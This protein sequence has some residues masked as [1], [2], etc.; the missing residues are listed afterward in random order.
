MSRRL[1][2]MGD[3]ILVRVDP[4]SD[5]V[6]SGLLFK[7]DDAHET[8]IQTGEVLDVGPGRWAERK[9]ERIPVGV[10]PG[11]GVVFIK[12]VATNTKTAQALQAHLNDNEAL[13]TPNDV[14]L[15][16]DRREGLKFG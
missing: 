1:R 8:I 4:E 11:E 10:E 13:L 15:V 6:A 3:R 5:M 14:L 16:Y 9:N 12:F 2:L 7:P